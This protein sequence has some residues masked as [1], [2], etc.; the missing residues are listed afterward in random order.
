MG[1]KTKIA[2]ALSGLLLF[3][4]PNL[5]ANINSNKANL[6]NQQKT[7][8]K[9]EKESKNKLSENPKK[10]KKKN[11]VPQVY[12]NKIEFNLNY[13]EV[14]IN[15]KIYETGISLDL[16]GNGQIKINDR[17]KLNLDSELKYQ[18]L[19][20]KDKDANQKIIKQTND[21]EGKVKIY[22]SDHLNLFLNIGIKS[23][24]EKEKLS[25]KNLNGH[26][27]I[28]GAGPLLGINLESKF[29][30]AKLTG[31]ILFGERKSSFD[32]NRDIWEQHAKLKIIPRYWI[33]EMPIELKYK[34]WEIRKEILDRNE[35]DII[36]N[37]KP[38]VKELIPNTTFF[39]NIIYNERKGSDVYSNHEVGGG[40]KVE[41]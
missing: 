35:Q 23:D 9:I 2:S 28:Y 29:V 34:H 27:T 32:I 36:F 14:K 15:N 10:N 41:W 12:K 26:I 16:E 4:S 38:G 22:S 33:F 30:D 1:L 17:F 19:I 37:I 20:I 24:F 7:E 31:A 21:L 25:Y 40:V 8:L 13:S 3:P 39:I 6:I 11:Y 5:N 18:T